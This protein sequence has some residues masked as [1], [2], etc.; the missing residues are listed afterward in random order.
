MIWLM[1]KFK[2]NYYEIR[3]LSHHVNELEK[4]LLHFESYGKNKKGINALNLVCPFKIPPKLEFFYSEAGQDVFVMS[5]LGGK[6]NG[7]FVEIGSQHPININNTYILENYFDWKGCMV[8]KDDHWRSMYSTHRNAD[9]KIDDATKINYEEWLLECQMPKT[10][11]YLSLDL[12]VNNN[13]TINCLKILP[14]KIFKFRI[15]TF[16]HDIYQSESNYTRDESRKMFKDYGYEL[17]CPDVKN[18]GLPY[19]DWYVHPDL[20]DMNKVD[21]IRTNHSQE[22]SEILWKKEI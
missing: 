1:I 17:I 4:S 2:Y 12:A 21:Q 15:I 9:Y 3:K 14:L 20:V 18:S 8:E 22:W 16:E 10:I 19:E 7:Y 11:D 5:V 6:R 13:S